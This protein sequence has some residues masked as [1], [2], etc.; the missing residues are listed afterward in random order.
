MPVAD[1][2]FP[3][4]AHETTSAVSRIHTCT[5][6]N[7]RTQASNS[8]LLC[9]R[10]S[11]A[12]ALRRLAPSSTL[13]ARSDST[14]RAAARTPSGS[15]QFVRQ[16]QAQVWFTCHAMFLDGAEILVSTPSLDV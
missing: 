14:A 4:L 12:A 6:A 3:K 7:S 15:L 8:G 2:S 9:V 16:Q 5:A 11:Y 13:R 10:R 1:W